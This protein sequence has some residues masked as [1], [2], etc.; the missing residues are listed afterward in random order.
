MAT[1]KGL[2]DEINKIKVKRYS[3]TAISRE[4]LPSA[5]EKIDD[6]LEI[7]NKEVNNLSKRIKKIE[8]KIKPKN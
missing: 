7:L 1:W 5:L 8:D 2:D 3:L 4:I 6:Q